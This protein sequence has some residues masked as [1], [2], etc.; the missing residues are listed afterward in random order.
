MLEDST[1]GLS[2]QLTFPLRCYLTVAGQGDSAQLLEQKNI[3]RF[4]AILGLGEATSRE[5]H[6]EDGG[7]VAE[8]HRL[9]FKINIVLELVSQLVAAGKDLPEPV[10][11]TLSSNTLIWVS[12]DNPPPQGAGVT[13]ELYLDLRFLFPVIFQGRVKS[14]ECF[15]PHASKIGVVFDPLPEPLQVMLEKY[16]F[17]CHRR[18]IAKLKKSTI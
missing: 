1:S 4:Q 5:F 14:L 11:A 9:D 13:L 16:I 10:S 18:H 17:R 6:E 2:C 3:N 8:I 12:S 7:V 15:S